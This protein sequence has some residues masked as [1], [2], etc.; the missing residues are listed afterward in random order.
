MRSPCGPKRTNTSAG[1][2]NGLV[3]ACGTRVSNSTTSPDESTKSRAPS[4]RRRRPGQDVQPFVAVVC[5]LL[6]RGGRPLCREDQLVGLQ[7]ALLSRE[8]HHRHAVAVER[9]RMDAR[10][11]RR[12]RLDQV[13][14]RHLVGAGQGQQQLQGRLAAAGLQPR[15]RAHRDAGGPRDRAEGEVPLGPQRP[16]ARTHRVEDVVHR[17]RIESL[18]H[19]SNHSCRSGH[20]ARPWRHDFP[21]PAVRR[22]DHRRGRRRTERGG[23]PGAL[24]PVGPRRRRG[25]SAQRPGRRRA[26]L[27]GPGGHTAR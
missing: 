23:G 6:G 24:A 11:G 15:E 17:R 1:S 25:P 12:R 19:S 9:A 27:P 18:C 5:L 20:A 7:P 22:R 10:V 4:C 3:K 21:R 13:V 2:G 8:R 16:E 14:Q 26:Q